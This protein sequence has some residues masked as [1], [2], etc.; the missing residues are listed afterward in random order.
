MLYVNDELFTLPQKERDRVYKELG[1]DPGKKGG[2]LKMIL[3]MPD[4][5]YTKTKDNEKPDRPVV[6]IIPMNAQRVGD[7]GS[8]K[9]NY[10]TGRDK[11]TKGGYSYFNNIQGRKSATI[12]FADK[13]ELG[14]GNIDLMYFLLFLSPLRLIPNETPEQAKLR[15]VR[16]NTRF[17]FVIENKEKEAADR[18]SKQLIYSKVEIAI[19][20]D[21]G[22]GDIKKVAG[23]MG[24]SGFDGKGE[25][26]LRDELLTFVV[27][28]EKAGR[29]GYEKFVSAAKLDEVTEVKSLIQEAIDLKVIKE[30][31]KTKR[32]CYLNGDGKYATQICGVVA[33]RTMRESL[34]YTLLSEPN[35]VDMLKTA[36]QEKKI[37]EE[38][39]A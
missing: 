16:P 4:S 31:P 8:E 15:G 20:Q 27:K 23:A 37:F 34:E 39:P 6:S 1:V 38:V 18:I 22:F 21:L 9:W 14:E 26:T 5:F 12:E 19:L 13:L 11:N 17:A 24:I 30:D 35:A 10:C 2:K 28:E 25:L 7:G 29:R 36:L 32:F 3:K 33:G